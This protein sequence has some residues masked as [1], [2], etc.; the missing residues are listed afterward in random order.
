M[1]ESPKKLS[2][3]QSQT[4]EDHAATVIR[5]KI[6]NIR[7]LASSPAP[8]GPV[9][10]GIT[11]T[12]QR[13]LHDKI[14]AA[15]QTVYDPEIPLNIY[16]LGLIYKLA[17]D[18]ANAVKVQMT[19]TAPGCPVAGSILA[20]VKRKIEA[21]PEVPKVDVE[22]VWDPPWT[23]DRLSEAARLQLGLF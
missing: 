16:D 21:I 23:R 22:L 1:S 10:E 9:A 17:I 19:L 14:V 4:E 12:D 18:P 15:L 2:L 8:A 3:T 5:E 11:A 13:V 7:D 20:E 6:G